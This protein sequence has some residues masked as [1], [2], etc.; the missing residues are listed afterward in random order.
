MYAVA[1]G[2]SPYLHAVLSPSLTFQV[3]HDSKVAGVSALE[4]L[5]VILAGCPC[6]RAVSED[7]E[8]KVFI[9][10]PFYPEGQVRFPEA[11][12]QFLEGPVRLDRP[13]SGLPPQ[14]AIRGYIGAS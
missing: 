8:Y 10:L 14:R 3:C 1:W 7:R 12:G 4:Y 6:L 11:L 2:Q 9:Q 5:Y 13:G